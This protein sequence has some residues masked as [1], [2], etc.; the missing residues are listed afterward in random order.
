ML[1]S[2]EVL[3]HPVFNPPVFKHL[4][5]LQRMPL[6][7]LI[8]KLR[9][10]LVFQAPQAPGFQSSPSPWFSTP[11][12]PDFQVPQA[13]CFKAPQAPGV[14]TPQTLTV[15]P[16]FVP[17][18][19]IIGYVPPFPDLIVSNFILPPVVHPNRIPNHVLIQRTI[20]DS[21]HMFSL[22]DAYHAQV[23]KEVLFHPVFN[24]TVFKHLKP[25]PTVFK[26]LKPLKP[27]FPKSLKPPAAPQASQ[28]PQFPQALKVQVFMPLKAPITFLY[29][30]PS[31]TAFT[32]FLL[33]M[34]IVSKEVLFHPVFNPTVFKHLKPLPTVFKL[35]K[36]LKPQF[37]KSLKPPA[38]PQASQ[39]PQFPQALKV[40]VFMPL[41]APVFNPPP[42]PPGVPHVV[43][44]A[45]VPLFQLLVM[46]LR[47]GNFLFSIIPHPSIFV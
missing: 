17:F 41:K 7:P 40:Q 28:A 19:I 38:A 26:L 30:G 4:N 10:P 45:F 35:L 36:P 15:P 6:K 46:F 34:H 42:P 11:Q 32:C 24:P 13:L 21:F 16:A 37:P 25:L 8:F 3:F 27:Q 33:Q 44:S 31:K 14:R 43:P 29:N 20:E 2:K 12:A 9:K 22:A 39:A 18:F 1:V 23:S 5:T 47:F